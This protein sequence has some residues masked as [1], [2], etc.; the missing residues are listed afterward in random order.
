M[1]SHICSAEDLLESDQEFVHIYPFTHATHSRGLFTS[2]G[3]KHHGDSPNG[4]RKRWGK[5]PNWYKL[6]VLVFIYYVVHNRISHIPLDR[7]DFFVASPR[8]P[9]VDLGYLH[10]SSWNLVTTILWVKRESL[11]SA[12]SP[13]STLITWVMRWSLLSTKN[14]H[15]YW[16]VFNQSIE[17]LL[18]LKSFGCMWRMI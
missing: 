8:T 10:L 12:F 9:P 16:T 13:T 2:G 4:F 1:T 7:Q 6:L 11:F 14:T 18:E 17:T 15:K 3:F 5:T